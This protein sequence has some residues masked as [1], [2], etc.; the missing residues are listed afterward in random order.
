MVLVVKVG[1]VAVIKGTKVICHS[2]YVCV[3]VCMCVSVCL[4]AEITEMNWI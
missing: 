3:C 2:V 1:A 4:R